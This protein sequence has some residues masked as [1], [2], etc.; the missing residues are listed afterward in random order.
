MH[1]SVYVYVVLH[2]IFHLHFPSSFYFIV[3]YFA[4]FSIILFFTFDTKFFPLYGNFFFKF[5]SHLF[6]C[7]FHFSLLLFFVLFSVFIFIPNSLPTN[8]RLSFLFCFL[9]LVTGYVPFYFSHLSFLFYSHSFNVCSLFFL[10]ISFPLSNSYV[11]LHFFYRH[12]FFLFTFSSIFFLLV[13][14]SSYFPFFHSS[15]IF[16]PLIHSN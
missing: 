1:I 14:G 2:V 6:F 8:T 13:S 9:Y 16:L 12:F 3:I 15:I 11:F 4:L 7:L 5:P 10:E